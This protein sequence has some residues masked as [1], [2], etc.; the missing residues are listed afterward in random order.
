MSTL[1]LQLSDL[2]DRQI[3]ALKRKAKKMGVTPASCV[4]QLIEDDLE[5]DD[6]ARTATF[7]EI[8]APFRQAMANST[9]EWMPPE[10]AII[11]KQPSES[12]I[13]PHLDPSTDTKIAALSAAT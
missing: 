2:P 9:A 13:T 8:A 12:D 7:N 5:L 4:R 3:S 1:S 11:R 6:I 10:H